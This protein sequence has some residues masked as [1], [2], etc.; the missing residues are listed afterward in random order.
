MVS[1]GILMRTQDSAQQRFQLPKSNTSTELSGIDRDRRRLVN[2]SRRDIRCSVPGNSRMRA[3]RRSASTAYAATESS[4][5]S[6]SAN[7]VIRAIRRRTSQGMVSITKANATPGAATSAPREPKRRIP[8]ISKDEHMPLAARRDRRSISKRSNRSVIDC[9]KRVFR[10]KVRG[11]SAAVL[12]DFVDS[13]SATCFKSK[14]PRTVVDS[15]IRK[16]CTFAYD[17]S[18][19]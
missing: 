2:T 13:T 17:R 12:R 9:L 3:V 8:P 4:G 5:F 11:R 16:S 6:P 10:G 18:L 7:F 1:P 15:L 14:L 19:L